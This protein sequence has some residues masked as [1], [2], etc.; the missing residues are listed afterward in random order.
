M[1]TWFD[2]DQETYDK[3]IRIDKLLDNSHVNLHGFWFKC[4]QDSANVNEYNKQ[5][6][7]CS[8][9]RNCNITG[10]NISGSID[11]PLPETL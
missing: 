2:S 11:D 3:N 9:D 7:Q 4:S 8:P 10:S 5:I 1:N 6:A